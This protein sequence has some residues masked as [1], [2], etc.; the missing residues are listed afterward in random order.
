M[1]NRGE[2]S[3]AA[4]TDSAPWI[5]AAATTHPVTDRHGPEFAAL[6]AQLLDVA[7]RLW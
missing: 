2:G 5:D 3:A 4:G 7:P 1:S 6:I